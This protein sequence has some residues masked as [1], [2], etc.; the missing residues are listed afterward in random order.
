MSRLGILLGLGHAADGI[1][2]AIF[3]LSSLQDLGAEGARAVGRRIWLDINSIY[4]RVGVV[5]A[6]GY[7]LVAIA[8]RVECVGMALPTASSRNLV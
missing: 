1:S 6:D 5:A 8:S 4:L 7:N 2:K 3:L